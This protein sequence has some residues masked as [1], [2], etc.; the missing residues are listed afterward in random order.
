MTCNLYAW[1]HSGAG[2]PPAPIKPMF[3]L[4]SGTHLATLPAGTYGA[5]FNPGFQGQAGFQWW[6]DYFLGKM[7]NRDGTPQDP[8]GHLK[9]RSVTIDFIHCDIEWEEN[10][11]EFPYFDTRVV[12]DRFATI[13]T[14][15][16]HFF[17][18]V[19]IAFYGD[20]WEVEHVAPNGNVT[21]KHLFH[22]WQNRDQRGLGSMPNYVNMFWDRS[23]APDRVLR[24][25]HTHHI[26]HWIEDVKVWSAKLHANGTPVVEVVG[27]KQRFA[28]EQKDTQLVNPSMQRDYGAALAGVKRPL[29]LYAA[30]NWSHPNAQAFVEGLKAATAVTS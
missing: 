14:I 13:R 23:W 26:I 9:Q 1:P 27:G 12:T 5:V 7:K 21:G 3:F 20:K 22:G 6:A 28:M 30:R 29:M 8:L 19:P 2:V 10:Q 18:N 15:L 17:P 11:L 24:L 4:D 16:K 25:S